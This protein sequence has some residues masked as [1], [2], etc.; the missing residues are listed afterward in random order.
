MKSRRSPSPRTGRNVGQGPAIPRARPDNIGLPR[1][2]GS[3][4]ASRPPSSRSGEG[5]APS[6]L[7]GPRSERLLTPPSESPRATAG[8]ASGCAFHRGIFGQR[9]I[10]GQPDRARGAV[11]QADRAIAGEGFRPPFEVLVLAQERD[12][13]AAG[14]PTLPLAFGALARRS[15]FR[16]ARSARSE[17]QSARST[18]LHSCH[19]SIP[20]RRHGWKRGTSFQG[21]RATEPIGET[22]TT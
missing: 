1:A 2:G 10:G 8:R 7:T 17:S 19:S 12:L 9:Q 11:E 15:P 18:S 6:G 13:A 20:L 3:N 22:A 16:S 21:S 14:H 4:L 5:Q